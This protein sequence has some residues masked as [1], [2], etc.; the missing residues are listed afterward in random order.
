MIG[1]GSRVGANVV[2]EK[3]EYTITDVTD[4][5]VVLAASDDMTVLIEPATLLDEFTRVKVEAVWRFNPQVFQLE[6]NYEAMRDEHKTVLKIALRACYEQ[7]NYCVDVEV[8]M[9]PKRSVF[10]RKAYRAN[11]LVLVPFTTNV[12]LA[13][14]ANGP[15]NCC[16]FGVMFKHPVSGRNIYGYAVAKNE[17]PTD[18]SVEQRARPKVS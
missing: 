17:L 14:S 18:P 9:K 7:H 10:T 2:R 16:S 11:E 6:S 8:Q 3:V 5:K 15:T 4:A 13:D 1:R 12:Y